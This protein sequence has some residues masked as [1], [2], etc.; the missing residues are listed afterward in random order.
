MLICPKCNLELKNKNEYVKHLDGHFTSSKKY[1]PCPTCN[2][3]F[4]GRTS[5]FLHMKDHETKPSEP[6]EILC[7][8]CK[9]NFP[10]IKEIETHFKDLGSNIPCPFC[11]AKP[12]KTYNAYAVHKHRYLL[13][14]TTI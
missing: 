10:S 6:K 7:R 11:K 13:M 4:T 1:Y 3:S 12:S 2:L 9:K 5:F 14:H 8:H